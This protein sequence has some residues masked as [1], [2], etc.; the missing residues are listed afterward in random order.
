MWNH[1]SQYSVS[2]DLYVEN[3]APPSRVELHQRIQKHISTL[4]MCGEE[5]GIDFSTLNSLILG[6]RV[7]MPLHLLEKCGVIDPESIQAS[8]A[9]P[10]YKSP[11]PPKELYH[12]FPPPPDGKDHADSSIRL[13]LNGVLKN[14][15]ACTKNGSAVMVP[16]VSDIGQSATSIHVHVNVTNEM[17]WPRQP[18]YL[19][20][21]D[22]SDLNTT[23]SLLCIIFGWIIFDRV[24]STFAMPNMIRDRSL[25]PMYAS[26]P[27][28][29]WMEHSWDQGKFVVVPD[30]DRCGEVNDIKPYNLP[31]WFRH[32]FNSYRKHAHGNHNHCS[33]QSAREEKKEEKSSLSSTKQKSDATS[34]LFLQVF[35]HEIISNTISR[36]NSLNL[37]SL[38]KYGTLEFRRM[39]ATLNPDFVSAW[40][41]FCVGFVEKF[42]ESNMF[43]K[44]LYPF[45]SINSNAANSS[46]ICDADSWNVGLERLVHAQNHATIEDLIEIMDDNSSPIIP[47]D[48][49]S[50]L[51]GKK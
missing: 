31:E 29:V 24:I 10:E 43:E 16:L 51:M 18:L 15:E 39:H 7:K 46:E 5:S 3:N 36:W 35:N 12:V 37:M 30:K 19:S 42:S 34:N 8:Q 17:A 26:G 44:F 20:T 27:E 28:F 2:H 22:D 25:A 48:T 4:E 45:I 50:I 41:W 1:L 49:I 32:V 33:N 11:L 38:K 21:Y 40:T 47:A 13:L 9:S 6:G 23:N 14:P